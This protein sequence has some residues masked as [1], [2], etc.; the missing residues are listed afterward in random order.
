MLC[1]LRYHVG[2]VGDAFHQT[3]RRGVV[4]ILDASFLAGLLSRFAHVVALTRQ[5]QGSCGFALV[6]ENLYPGAVARTTPTGNV[7]RLHSERRAQVTRRWGTKVNSGFAQVAS[8][9]R[10]FLRREFASTKMVRL[11]Q[12]LA[13]RGGSHSSVAGAAVRVRRFGPRQHLVG[14]GSPVAV[15]GSQDRRRSQLMPLAS[16]TK[17]RTSL[18]RGFVCLYLKN[19]PPKQDFFLI[20]TV[21]KRAI[22]QL[23]IGVNFLDYFISRESIV[24]TA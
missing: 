7:G 24:L 17:F 15:G 3:R 8:G 20:E 5:L 10:W 19:L 14:R 13:D 9:S 4:M 21:F 23:V 22:M 1:L 16:Q 12:R 11:A 2:V 18:V 6:A